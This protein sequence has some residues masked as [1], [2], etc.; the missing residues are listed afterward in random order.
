MSKGPAFG[1]EDR[2]V[3]GDWNITCS[4]CGSKLKFGEAVRNWQGA[5]RHQHCDEPRHPQDFVQSLPVPEMAIP[6]VQIMGEGQIN[7][8][9]FNGLSAIPGY[10]LPGCSIPG[11]TMIDPLSP[12]T[13]LG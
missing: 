4:M 12:P 6:V 7:V 13:Q 8:C 3:P 11:R 5:W 10:A 2:F 9:T 1:A